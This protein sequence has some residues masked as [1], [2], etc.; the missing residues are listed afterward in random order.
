MSSLQVRELPE[1][2]YH[3]LQSE[4]K[5][6]HRSLA[7]QAVVTIQKGLG[8]TEEPKLRRQRLLKSFVENP[9]NFNTKNLPK[10]AKLI[11]EDR[12]R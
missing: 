6:M 9:I 4:A 2:I 5:K 12:D 3:K 11:R 8:I 7:Q 1:N 10:P